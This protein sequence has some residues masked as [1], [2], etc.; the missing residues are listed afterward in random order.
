MLTQICQVA[1]IEK[2]DNAYAD[3][4]LDDYARIY[5]QFVGKSPVCII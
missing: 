2:S 3:N 4:D 1:I 5:P